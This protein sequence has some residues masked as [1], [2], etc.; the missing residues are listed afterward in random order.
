L[1]INNERFR[2]ADGV[3]IPQYRRIG[4]D[5]DAERL[6]RLV[7]ELHFKTII[8]NDRTAEEMRQDIND[9][10]DDCILHSDKYDAVCLF[11]LSHGGSDGII[12]GVDDRNS[13][14]VSHLFAK[15]TILTLKQS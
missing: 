3:E 8:R 6:R 5:K 14:N 1:I 7:E 12:F 4:T 10:V 11:I 15:N 13:I 9:L 2:T